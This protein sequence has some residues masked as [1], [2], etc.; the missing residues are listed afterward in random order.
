MFVIND[1][2]DEGSNR[3]FTLGISLPAFMAPKIRHPSI[4]PA[5]GHNPHYKD[6]QRSTPD[7][8]PHIYPNNDPALVRVV[9][10]TQGLLEFRD[11]GLGF[12]FRVLYTQKPQILK[13]PSTLNPKSQAILISY[14]FTPES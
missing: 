8:G 4:N 6:Q 13:R 14:T 10:L 11:W 9:H 3:V 12:G 7:I 1:K 5:K 2:R